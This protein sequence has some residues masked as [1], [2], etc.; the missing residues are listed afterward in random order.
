MKKLLIITALFTLFSFTTNKEK[1]YNVQ[2]SESQ[3]QMAYQTLEACKQAVH[4]S[5]IPMVQG[6][7]LLR[8]I[9]SLQHILSITYK[10]QQDTTKK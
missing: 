8:N 5:Q 3:I 1:Q 7:Q 4:T 2:L 6:E 10:N 9:D